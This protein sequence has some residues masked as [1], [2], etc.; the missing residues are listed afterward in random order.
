MTYF[1]TGYF[2][3]GYWPAE[4]WPVW[5]EAQNPDP[6]YIFEQAERIFDFA[7]PEKMLSYIKETD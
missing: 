2:V 4:Y 5:G 1:P 7:Q 3:D 6:F